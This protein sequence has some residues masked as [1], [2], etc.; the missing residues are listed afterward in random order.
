[1]ESRMRRLLILVLICVQ[2]GGSG[3]AALKGWWPQRRPPCALQPGATKDEIV[4]QVNRNFAAAEGRPPLTAW[5]S[6]HVRVTSPSFPGFLEANVEVEA[7]RNLRIRAHNPFIGTEYVDVGSNA[8]EVWFWGTGAPGI[9]TVGHDELPHALQTMQVPFQP[10]WLME[11]LGATPIDGEEYALV[12]PE[13]RPGFVE[14]VAERVSPAGDRVRRVVSVDLCFGRILEHRLESADGGLIARANLGKYELDRATGFH[15]PH[16]VHVQWPQQQ[17]ELTLQI[18]PIQANP[19]PRDALAW[20]VPTKP[21]VPVLRPGNRTSAARRDSLH[22]PVQYERL[23]E[24]PA[25]PAAGQTSRL[26]DRGG[27]PHIQPPSGSDPA[28]RLSLEPLTAD[29]LPAEHSPAASQSSS[30][31]LPRGPES[32]P[33]PFPGPR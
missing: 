8:D 31:R 26:R 13:T 12:Y 3:C 21:G 5:R 2:P 9:V 23:D 32:T 19:P 18:G 33:L 30:D 1:M 10:E 16:L 29:E 6:T 20:S 28:V 24:D 11:I 7:P 27:P 22:Q 15:L 25:L 4:A 17:T 14:L